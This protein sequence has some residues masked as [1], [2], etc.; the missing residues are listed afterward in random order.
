MEN[1]DAPGVRGEPGGHR[2]DT[3]RPDADAIR[4]THIFFLLM[5]PPSTTWPTRSSKLLLIVS[6]GNRPS[7]GE[8]VLQGFVF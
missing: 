5:L 4:R 6:L 1:S 7:S 3:G 2:A 8:G